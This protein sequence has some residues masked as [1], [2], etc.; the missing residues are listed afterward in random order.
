MS[1]SNR[2]S[3]K[4]FSDNFEPATREHSYEPSAAL[5]RR[6]KHFDKTYTHYEDAYST[7]RK[8]PDLK[9]SAMDL[10]EF[11]AAGS[12]DEVQKLL[13]VGISAD[14][15]DASG[16]PATCAAAIAGH[17]AIVAELLSSGASALQSTNFKET[18]LH[19]ACRIGSRDC[20]LVIIEA[21][22]REKTLRE[23]LEAENY[24]GA[25]ALHVASEKGQ[26]E[27]CRQ[28]VEVGADLTAEDHS[29][30]TALQLAVY[31]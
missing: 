8:S 24:M 22:K 6:V 18:P 20:A 28:L 25:R 29:G 14:A 15:V 30:R 4:P 3:R 19:L 2:R 9:P 26:H 10:V 1:S 16:E 7:Y 27:V 5:G 23:L 11:A 31:W 13:A 21:S 17:S 12:L